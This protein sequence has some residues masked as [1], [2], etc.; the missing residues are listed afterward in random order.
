ML[1]TKEKK[2]IKEVI[3]YFHK[4]TG[5]SYDDFINI[6]YGLKKVDNKVDWLSNQLLINLN[7]RG[8]T[9]EKLIKNKDVIRSVELE[10]KSRE[11][12]EF[13]TPED[14]AVKGREYLKMMLGDKWG[15]I[16]IWDASCGTGNLLRTVDYPSEKLFMSTLLEE[17]VNIVKQEKKDCE[18]FQLDF[19]N[20]ID[21]DE[22]NQFF[23]SKLPQSLQEILKNDSG[24][25]FY[26]NPPYKVKSS[27]S[28][29]LGKILTDLG[30]G[31][32]ALDIFHH[33][34]YRMLLLKR[35]HGLKDMYVGVFSPLT[36]FHSNMVKPL[37]DEWRKDFVFEG[38]FCFD[39]GYFSNTSDSVG[40][41]IGFTMWRVKNEGEEDKPI[42]LDTLEKDKYGNIIKSGTKN[43]SNVEINLHDWVKPKDILRKEIE[44][45]VISSYSSFKGES[46]YTS[47]D[48][49]GF[50]MS[51]NFV[52]RSIRRRA[53]ATLPLR[54]S[55]EITEEN[56]W[57]CVSS[58]GARCIYKTD[59][60]PFSNS[61]YI[62]APS[63]K[64]KGY[65][66]WLKDTLMIALFGYSAIQAS[67]RGIDVN[68]EKIDQLN[69]FFPIEKSVLKQY[70][71]D[72]M[73]LKDME[74]T[75]ERNQ[76]VV[77]VLKENVTKMSREALDLY[78]FCIEMI[79]RSV[80]TDV[81]KEKGYDNWLQSWDAGWVQI[82]ETLNE[83]LKNE[84]YFRLNK[85]K[86]KLKHGV[87]DFD[88]IPH[89]MEG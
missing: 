67:Y 74:E 4:V 24:L 50:L 27:D 51:S 21:I 41:V 89:H 15:S 86:D 45:P 31:K 66:E 32:C 9:L 12:G 55:I 49:L 39:A 25:C 83:D 42:T 56:F 8:I 82:K 22:N 35:F 70:T 75:D 19:L 47:K 18:V 65:E 43:V 10:K 3:T 20:G 68:G 80:T 23:T 5:L 30:M 77:S 16:A 1:S 13:Y 46:I 14:W 52:I 33:F 2:Y 72:E 78:E 6:H 61:S 26:M 81:R 79:L 62:Q 60:N 76:F 54:D 17:D 71:T 58:F 63:I 57:R 44:L 7:N 38:G 36:F 84:Y 88:F 29:D 85:L 53:I 59:E 48:T 34:M 37:Y 28:T 87:Y 69:V 64:K 11:E 73:V 40:W